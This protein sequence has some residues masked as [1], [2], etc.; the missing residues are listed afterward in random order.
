MELLICEN[1]VQTKYSC[2]FCPAC[3]LE[4]EKM[5]H[6][7]ACVNMR[8]VWGT[9]EDFWKMYGNE[10]RD[11]KLVAIALRESRKTRNISI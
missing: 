11:I 4:E 5:H 7:A 1:I 3:K 8:I 2:H 10:S 9:F 6:L